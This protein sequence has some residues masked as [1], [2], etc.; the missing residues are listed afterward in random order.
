MC[1]LTMRSFWDSQADP[2]TAQSTLAS[3]ITPTPDPCNTITCVLYCEGE[4]GWSRPLAKCMSVASSPG[5]RTEQT[6]ID[7]RLGD[8]PPLGTRDSVDP[9]KQPTDTDDDSSNPTM[10]IVVILVGHCLSKL[11]LTS[12][13]ITLLADPVHAS[14]VLFV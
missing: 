11:I 8:C 14:S 13:A 2:G 5:L 7:Q 4:C 9:I 3:N 1:L 12:R 6:E 10:L